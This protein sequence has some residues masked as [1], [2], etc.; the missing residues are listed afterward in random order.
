VFTPS[1]L[2]PISGESDFPK[3]SGTVFEVESQTA[4][5][6]LVTAQQISTAIAKSVAE[7]DSNYWAAAGPSPRKIAVQQA[8]PEAIAPAKNTTDPF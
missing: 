5:Y 7:K 4:A 8:L 1:A 3:I 6:E 2:I